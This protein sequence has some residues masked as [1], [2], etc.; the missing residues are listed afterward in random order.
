MSKNNKQLKA[1]VITAEGFED[2]EV[3]YP[4]IRLKEEGFVV[5]IATKDAKPVLGRLN[6]PLELIVRYYG[7]LVDAKKLNP[8]SYDLVLI[9]GGFEAP[10]RMRQVPEILEFIRKMNKQKKIVAAFC[11]GP[12]VLISAGIVRGKKIAGYIGIK[13]D[14]NN[15]GAI[16]T[17]KP[18][19]IDGNIVTA[20]HPRDVTDLMKAIF[21]KFK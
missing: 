10:D 2:E 9:P 13:D 11:H 16:Y 7:T 4:V 3:I 18:A 6:F 5:D 19:V 20:R 1:V 17:D 21:S 8:D 12:W 14:I 15:A